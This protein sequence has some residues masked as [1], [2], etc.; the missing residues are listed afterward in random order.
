[1]KRL[2]LLI[3]VTA[4]LWGSTV[5]AQSNRE[6]V[7]VQRTLGAESH[8]TAST[9]LADVDGDGDIDILFAE[10]RHWPQQNRIFLNNGEGIFNTVRH[11][12]NELT[13]SYA[14]R[15]ADFDGDGDLD[16]VV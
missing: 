13:T 1:V 3:L 8:L 10:G 2:S 4:C 11:L 7:P 12:G 14:A 5:I 6:L 16:I 15:T 9:S